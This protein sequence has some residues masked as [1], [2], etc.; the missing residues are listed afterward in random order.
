LDLVNPDQI[1]QILLDANLRLG[2]ECYETDLKRPKT[3]KEIRQSEAK[4]NVQIG[5]GSTAVACLIYNQQIFVSNVGDSL[6]VLLRRKK[7][8]KQKFTIERLTVTHSLT[9]LDEKARIEKAKGYITKAGIPKLNGLTMSRAFGDAHV[10][11]GLTWAPSIPTSI[12]IGEDE[13]AHV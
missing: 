11:A 12:T 1:P 3:A 4:G 9:D 6:A 8:S 13:E 5:A 7:N 2:E 10:G